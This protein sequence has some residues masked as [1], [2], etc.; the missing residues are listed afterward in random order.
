M[1]YGGL[2]II[3][4]AALF[5]CSPG[6]NTPS[7]KDPQPCRSPYTS[8]FAKAHGSTVNPRSPQWKKQISSLVFAAQ[9]CR[10]LETEQ[11]ESI[12][13][14]TCILHWYCP[15]LQS[16]IH[17]S[18]DIYLCCFLIWLPQYAMRQVVRNTFKQVFVVCLCF[19]VFWGRFSWNLCCL[20]PIM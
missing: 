19:F 14:D 16:L 2:W 13:A 1:I 18:E 9:I 7:S 6:A 12:R 5:G 11:T 20:E 10:R 15:H 17:H 3:G 8:S 4:I